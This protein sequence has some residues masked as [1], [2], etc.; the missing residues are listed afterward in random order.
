MEMSAG[1]G[2]GRLAAAGR[3][4]GTWL[5]ERLHHAGKDVQTGEGSAG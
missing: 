2:K 4:R 5:F 3:A 1:E